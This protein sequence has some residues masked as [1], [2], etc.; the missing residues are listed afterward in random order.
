M[1]AFV[2][3]EKGER[4]VRHTDLWPARH[5]GFALSRAWHAPE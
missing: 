1:R 2:G 4:D 5:S 3:R